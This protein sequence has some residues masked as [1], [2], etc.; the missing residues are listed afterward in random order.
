MKGLSKYNYWERLSILKMLSTE[1]RTERYKILYVWKMLNGTVPNLG[2]QVASE[3]SSRLGL[4]IRIPPKSGLKDSVQSMKDQFLTTH[5]PRLFNSLSKC[6]WDRGHSFET[7]K[8]MVD[9]F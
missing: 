6:V 1:R 4:T 2:L 8:K 5:G 3:E 7:F 9:D